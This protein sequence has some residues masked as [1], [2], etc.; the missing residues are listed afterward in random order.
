MVLK[1]RIGRAGILQKKCSTKKSAL[2]NL[3]KFK[4]NTCIGFFLNNIA[5]LLPATLFKKILLHQS[6]LLNTFFIEHLEA[7]ASD[8]FR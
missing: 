1:S 4:E 6:I 8:K 2:K 5:H 7:T 3:T